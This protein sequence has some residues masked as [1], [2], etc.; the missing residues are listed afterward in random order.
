MNL[1]LC[2]NKR[3]GLEVLGYIIEYRLCDELF[4]YTDEGIVNDYCKENNI[5]Y[6][7]DKIDMSNL[8][9]V[10]DLISSVY[11]NYIISREVIDSCGG[12]I[13]NAHPS[14]LP[15]H[16]GCSS[17]PWAIIEGDE[18]TALTFHYI[19]EKIDEGNIILQSV[20][21]ISKNETQLSLYEKCMQKAID[22]WPAAFC[23]VKF[24][25]KG[26]EQEAEPASYH[27]RGCPYNGEIDD[28]WTEEKTE[29][30]IRAMY[31]P[32]LPAAKYKG[33]YLLPNLKEGI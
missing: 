4:V 17:V 2:C 19:N 33:Q 28:S 25:F 6:T 8:P 26:V 16:R 9:F 7:T 18:I 31:F 30:F 21:H 11:Y 22:F 13:F 24:G 23:L 5:K 1:V 32:P 3:A 29:R 15:K 14:A 12:K 10:P 27:K 20:I